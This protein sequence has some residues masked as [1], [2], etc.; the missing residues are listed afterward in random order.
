MDT[1][2]SPET[3]AQRL[4]RTM[5]EKKVK[6]DEL[7]SSAGKSRQSIGK[8]MYGASQPNADCIKAIAERLEVSA[9]Y[10]VMLT[11]NPTKSIE[12]RAITE[13]TGLSE[14]AIISLEEMKTRTHGDSNAIILNELLEH[15]FIERIIDC[16]R[17]CIQY[18]YIVSIAS[19]DIA[20]FNMLTDAS[21]SNSTLTAESQKANRAERIND[22]VEWTFSTL[23]T[24]IYNEVILHFENTANSKSVNKLLKEKY[25]ELD[26]DIKVAL[27]RLIVLTYP[28]YADDSSDDALKKKSFLLRELLGVQ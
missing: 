19:L 5:D 15:G 1:A 17:D 25:N 13:K 6:Q 9:D 11:D 28:K 7:A 10:L 21:E 8:Y 3:F 12:N 24:K 2:T 27:S 16:F 26:D 14:S 20:P 23:M 4:I 22:Y 18:S